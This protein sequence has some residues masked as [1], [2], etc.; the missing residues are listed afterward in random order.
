M[1]EETA[2]ERP[3]ACEP[4]HPVVSLEGTEVEVGSGPQQGVE[5]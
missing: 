2:T 4:Q 1:A 3:G 5:G